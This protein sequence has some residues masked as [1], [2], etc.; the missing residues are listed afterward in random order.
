MVKLL[1]FSTD[2]FEDME[3]QN[4]LVSLSKL[5]GEKSIMDTLAAFSERVAPEYKICTKA[6]EN[7][8]S[9]QRGLRS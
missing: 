3:E 7:Y 8:T 9:I 6:G 2:G 4:E 1:Q 5:F